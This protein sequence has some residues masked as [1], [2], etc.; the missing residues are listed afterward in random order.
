MIGSLRRVGFCTSVRPQSLVM[1]E[2]FAG[3]LQLVVTFPRNQTIFHGTSA[4]L[5]QVT[6][7]ILSFLIR[8]TRSI[9][10]EWWKV[11]E[12]EPVDWTGPHLGGDV[13]VLRGGCKRTSVSF[14]HSDT[15][16]I[17]SLPRCS[18]PTFYNLQIILYQHQH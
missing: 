12:K 11:R 5:R 17:T 16:P 8:I 15:S 1:A 6:F 18:L 14:Y 4:T 9:S 2:V 7:E 13:A 10:G 3:F